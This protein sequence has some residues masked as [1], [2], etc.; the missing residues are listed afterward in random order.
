MLLLDF[1]MIFLHRSNFKLKLTN[2]HFVAR[3]CSHLRPQGS[4][5]LISVGFSNEKLCASYCARWNLICPPLRRDIG[6]PTKVS[7]SSR[8]KRLFED[9]DND[10][11]FVQ[12][13]L[14]EIDTKPLFDLEPDE[15]I[16]DPDAQRSRICTTG[17]TP[18]ITSSF[19]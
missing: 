7:S 19:F 10:D 9:L 14:K 5:P 6:S 8:C 15:L 16:L 4:P 18:I 11:G 13:P 12:P 1:P 17:F 2:A 3:Q